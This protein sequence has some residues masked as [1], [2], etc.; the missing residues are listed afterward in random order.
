M[1]LGIGV[2][3]APFTMFH[4]FD[5]PLPRLK[6]LCDRSLALMVFEN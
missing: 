4:P 2:N 3:T 6:Q 1:A 5:R